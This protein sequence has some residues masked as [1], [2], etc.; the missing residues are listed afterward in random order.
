M[1]GR[2]VEVEEQADDL[3]RRQPEQQ[4]EAEHDH[5]P[6][7][8]ADA[9]GQSRLEQIA[10][11]VVLADAHGHRVGN[12]HGHHERHRHRLQGDLMRGHLRT[13]HR[14]HAER[15][16]GEQTNLDRIGAANRQAE[17]PQLLQ[18]SQRGAH[19]ALANGVGRIGRVLADMQG[20]E[21][22]HAVGNHRSD[23]T[24]AHQ[25]Q[26]RQAKQAMNECIV[27]PEVHRHAAQADHHHR[28]GTP[29]RAGEATQGH[30]GQ[31]TGQGQ[32]QGDQELPGHVHVCLILPKPEQNGLK[33]PQHQGRDQR[34]APRQPQSR[35]SQPRGAYVVACTVTDRD[36]RA[37]GGDNPHAE[38]RNQVVA[39]R[40]Q[41]AASQGIGSQMTHHHGVSKNHE[42]V[43]HLRGDQRPGQAQDNPQ[44]A[45]PGVLSGCS[46][47]GR[48]AR[49][50]R[51]REQLILGISHSG[52][53]GI[54]P[55]IGMSKTHLNRV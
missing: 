20:Q 31:K 37:D 2:I 14:A 5:C 51:F 22:R 12:P 55:M 34:H 27:K 35:L 1:V 10:R 9:P 30:K 40:A 11:A 13:A 49:R 17:A 25:A 23:Q 48:G 26:M 7:G 8:N 6:E 3:I 43:R 19:Q 47:H 53:K 16:E 44:F 52:H 32:G 38:E 29:Q 54:N 18:I 21:H 4:R 46:S 33:V 45:D 28:A 50:T 39:G 41:P 24:D 15:R 42:H 36:Q